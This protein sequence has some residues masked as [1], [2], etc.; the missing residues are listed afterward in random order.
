MNGNL[1]TNLYKFIH[2][3]SE[4]DEKLVADI[5]TRHLLV[6]DEMMGG[7]AIESIVDWL[8]RK[9]HHRNTS[10]IYITQMVFDRANQHRFGV[11]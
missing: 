6:F 9:A 7:K 1:P 11:V 5:S 3:I 2:S 4:D 10:V 8:T